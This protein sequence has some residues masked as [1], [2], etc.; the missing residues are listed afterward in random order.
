MVRY[1]LFGSYKDLV[2][3][4]KMG[5][6]HIGQSPY[7]LNGLVYLIFVCLAY[8]NVLKFVYLMNIGNRWI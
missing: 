4:V 8:L 2:I 7:Y 5:D 6:Q 3:D 1:R